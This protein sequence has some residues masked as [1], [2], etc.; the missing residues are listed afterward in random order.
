MNRKQ[1]GK[2]AVKRVFMGVLSAL[3]AGGLVFIPSLAAERKN[4]P[5][6]AEAIEAVEPV[7]SVRVTEV[8][9][10]TLEAYLAVNGTIVSEHQVEVFPETSGKLA[11][12]YAALG[13]RVGKGELIAEVDPSRPGAVYSHSPVYAPIAGTVCAVPLAAGSTVSPL[14]SVATIAVVENLEIEALIPEREVSQLA[15]NLSA[16]GTLQAFPGE[17]FNARVVRVSPVLDPYSR[18]KKIVLRFEKEDGRINAGM[19]A[20]LKINTRKYP[21]VLTVPSEAVLNDGYGN[22]AVYVCRDG[23]VTLREVSI[24]VTI[25]RL[26]EIKAGLSPDEAVVI[27]GQQFLSDGVPVRL[28]GVSG[29]AGGKA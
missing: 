4:T 9:K 8:E 12:L 11:E 26:T 5:G 19:F 28:I 18:T 10:R 14:N 17:V 16:R 2:T 23:R 29:K 3:V 20:R 21:D 7:F 27:Q 25:D 15:I 24:G 6:T 1:N 13:T 22:T